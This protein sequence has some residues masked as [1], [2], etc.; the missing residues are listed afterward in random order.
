MKH[1]FETA[2]A[3]WTS[4]RAFLIKKEYDHGRLSTKEEAELESLQRLTSLRRNLVAPI[5][6]SELDASIHRL[7]L[8]GQLTTG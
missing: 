5:D 7:K 3:H 1:V 8:A 2:T 4:R 6:R